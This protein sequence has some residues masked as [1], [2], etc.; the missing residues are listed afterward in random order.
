V[1]ITRYFMLSITLE[2]Y[3]PFAAPGSALAL[4]P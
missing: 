1:H 3:D 2:A 4:I